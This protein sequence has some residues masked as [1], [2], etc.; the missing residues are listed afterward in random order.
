ML[1]R[2]EIEWNRSQFIHQ[3][4]RQA[5]LCKIDGLDIGVAGIAA[6]NADVGKLF[7]SVDRKFGLVFLA[8]SRADDATEFPFA[9]AKAAD[10]VASRAIALGAKHGKGG[11][12]ITERAQPVAITVELQARPQAGELSAGLKKGVRQEFLRSV[13]LPIGH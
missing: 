7:G 3:R 1:L 12:P 9:E 6:L 8:A 13:G 11:P 10:Q 5:V 2:P 4:V